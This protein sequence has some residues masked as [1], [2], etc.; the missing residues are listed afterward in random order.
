[1]DQGIYIM[2]AQLVMTAL[3]KALEKIPH[4]EIF[5]TDQSSQYASEVHTQ[6]LKKIGTTISV[7]SKVRVTDDICIEYLW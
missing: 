2:N 1:M 4:L 7:N 6:R 5:N 3:N